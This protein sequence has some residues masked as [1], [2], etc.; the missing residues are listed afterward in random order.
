LNGKFYP[1]YLD[2]NIVF[3]FTGFLQENV[4]VFGDILAFKV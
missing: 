3:G 2:L 4:T 1:L